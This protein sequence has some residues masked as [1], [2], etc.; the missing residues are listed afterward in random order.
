LLVGDRVLDDQRHH[1]L[2]MGQRQTEADRAA[3]ILQIEA[4]AGQAARLQEML[5]HLREV[6]EGVREVRG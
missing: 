2:G 3:V 1:A 6:V 5:H 4:V